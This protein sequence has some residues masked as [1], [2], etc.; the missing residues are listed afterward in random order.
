MSRRAKNAGQTEKAPR[1]TAPPSKHQRSAAGKDGLPANYWN[2]CE[3]V[4][5]GQYAK[6]RALYAQLERSAG[7]PGSRLRVLIQNDLGVIAAMEG[8]LDEA[9]QGWRAA[10]EGGSECLPARLNLGLV[11]AEL[12]RSAPAAGATDLKIARAPEESEPLAADGSDLPSAFLRAPCSPT[13]VAVIS[14]LFNWPS[15]GGGNMHTAGL[16]E[17]LGRDGFDARHFY[18]RYP[19]WGIGR[20]GDDGL[21]ASEAIE[22]AESEWDVQAIRQRFRAAVDAFGPDYVVISDTWNMK[23]H[24]AEAM[25]GYP[26]LLMEQAQ[27]CLCP[28]NNLR[29]IGIGPTQVEQCPRNQLATPQVCHQCVAER[30]HHAGAL[31]QVERALAGVGTAEYDRILRQSFLE[32]EA[33]LVLNPIT[34]AMLEPYAKRVCIVPWGIDPARFPCG[35]GSGQFSD[36]SFQFSVVGC[37]DDVAGVDARREDGAARDE[38]GGKRVSGLFMAAVAGEV[39]KGFHVAHEA[40]RILRETR[41]DIELVVTFD[42]AGPIDEFTRSVGWCS[43]AELPRH[44]M[45]ADICLVPTIAQDALSIT[46]VEAMAAGKPV[47]ASRIGGLPYTVSDGLTGL[48]F[49]PGNPWDLAEKIARLLDDPGLRREMGLAGRRRFEEDFMWEDVIKRYWRPLLAQRASVR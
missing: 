23:P 8:K 30:G 32:A 20:V 12:V 3:L 24:L 17:F 45:A 18:A 38:G 15:T 21:P 26:T 11:E 35:K 28:L 49:E 39:I 48:L 43:Q 36:F 27:E 31:H 42:P 34:A 46:S 10:I 5:D 4:R 44:Y 25:R 16:V 1:R 47:V 40:C 14:F 33:V 9:C 37:S 13:R 41:N 6:A 7:K 22:F 2:A 29:L 19:A